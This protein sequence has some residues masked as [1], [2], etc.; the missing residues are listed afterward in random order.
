[1]AEDIKMSEFNE[2]ELAKILGLDSSGNSKKRNYH[3]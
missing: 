3:L 1:M 2:T